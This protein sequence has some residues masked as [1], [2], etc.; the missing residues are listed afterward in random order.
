MKTFVSFFSIFLLSYSSEAQ[1]TVTKVKDIN[2][3]SSSNVSYLTAFNDKIIFSASN[4]TYSTEP[5][6]SDGTSAGTILLKNINKSG[7]SN[8]KAFVAFNG[9]VF[10]VAL[11][12]TGNDEIWY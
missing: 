7:S 1:L 11:D 4:L 3:V 10:F 6:I 8:P 5:W 12:T 9:K 2:S